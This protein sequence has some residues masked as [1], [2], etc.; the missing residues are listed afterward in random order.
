M[1]VEISNTDVADLISTM[2]EARE[3]P[4]EQ[5]SAAFMKWLSDHGISL[6]DIKKRPA[7]GQPG[8][9]PIH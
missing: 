9:T 7:P 8:Y 6:D 4:R 1:T 3:L 2:Q 5:R